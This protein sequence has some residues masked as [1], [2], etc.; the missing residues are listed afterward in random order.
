MQI[1]FYKTQNDGSQ[2][3]A[4]RAS[5]EGQR[6]VFHGLDGDTLEEIQNYGILVAGKVYFPE[7]G[8]KFLNALPIAYSGSRYRAGRVD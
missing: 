5:L 6:V 2:I 4:G 1:Q 3:P 8:E 7:D